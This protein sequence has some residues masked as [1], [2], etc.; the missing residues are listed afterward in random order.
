VGRYLHENSDI[1]EGELAHVAA[2]FQMAAIDVLSTKLIAAAK[3]KNCT[4]IGISGGVSANRTFVDNLRKRAE[5]HQ[6]NVFSPP[7]SLCGDNAAMIAA[8]GWE[9]IRN[10]QTCGLGDDVYSRVKSVVGAAG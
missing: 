4:V 5:Q 2:G 3:E 9:M 1:N 7:L 10:N 8:R 6:I